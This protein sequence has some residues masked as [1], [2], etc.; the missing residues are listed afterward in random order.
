VRAR[1]G[2]WLTPLVLSVWTPCFNS[3]FTVL[4]WPLVAALISGVSPPRCSEFFSA[5][6]VMSTP[7]TSSMPRAAALC[8]ARNPCCAPH[9]FPSPS[10]RSRE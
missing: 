2:V 4:A 7:S 6:A 10:W 3:S 5:P 8:I 1:L 9:N